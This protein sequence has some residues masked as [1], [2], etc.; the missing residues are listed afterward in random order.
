MGF[1][2]YLCTALASF[3]CG[4]LLWVLCLQRR[5]E[6]S[7][8]AAYGMP[9]SQLTIVILSMATAVATAGIA[10]GLSMAWAT[11][12]WRE[13]IRQLLAELGIQA[14]PVEVLDMSLP[15]HTTP[16]LYLT[17]AFFTFAMVILSSVPA[18]RLIL[19]MSSHAPQ[20]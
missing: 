19:L 16:G 4:A 12:H 8:M 7:I 5:R 3:A 1:I 14:F 2:L 15:A 10:L 17:H 6:L 11:V 13:P 18:L 20:Q 9:P